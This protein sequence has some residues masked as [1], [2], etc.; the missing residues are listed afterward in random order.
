MNFF[1]PHRKKTQAVKFG[2][3]SKKQREKVEDE[4]RFHRAQLVRPG[5][6]G[7]T[8]MHGSGMTQIVTASTT[9]SPGSGASNGSPNGS[10]T[11]SQLHGQ[12]QLGATTT[13]L[14]TANIATSLTN[15]HH[16]TAQT[17]QQQQQHHQQASSGGPPPHPHA[18][19][20]TYSTSQTSSET[21]PDSSVLEQQPAQQPSSSS[22][23]V[24]YSSLSN[25]YVVCNPLFLIIMA[26]PFICI[27][28]HSDNAFL[29]RCF[30]L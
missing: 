20:T 13:L 26:C 10:L 15:N 8:S 25:G 11:I 3:M 30:C 9:T 24:S 27:M 29:W 7:G 14:T 4:V 17:S 1:L 16:P 21:S 6:G 19:S 2:R 18:T 28:H 22:Q 12:T 5:T 23:H